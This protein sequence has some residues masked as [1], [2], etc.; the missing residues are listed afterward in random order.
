LHD[1]IIKEYTYAHFISGG[2]AF[3]PYVCGMGYLSLFKKSICG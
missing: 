1:E 2:R 3:Y